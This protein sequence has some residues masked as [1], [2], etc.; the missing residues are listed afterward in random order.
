MADE[1]T[2]QNT[3]AQ[4]GASQAPAAS[5]ASAGAPQDRRAGGRGGDNRGGQGGFKK[6]PRR[7]GR[8][9]KPRSE[10]DQKIIDI[11][12]VT[13]VV[14]GGRRFAF[15]VALVAGNKK[16]QVGVGIGKAGDTSLA[17]D[18]ALKNAK[19]HMIKVPLNKHASIPHEV[20]AKYCAAR[21]MITPAPGRGVIAGSSVRNV[22]ELAGIKDVMAKIHSGS[23]NRLNNARV[24]IKALSQ[25]G[26]HERRATER[27]AEGAAASS[28]A[29][30]AKSE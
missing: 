25:L 8:E 4:Q 13:R 22:I 19:K 27:Q 14:S 12:R 26:L 9:G 11:R 18:K 29:T 24:A 15:S 5:T 20:S 3:P 10:F 6:N 30:A 17:I 2:Q 16:G 21:V 28:I 23:K 7:G 1:M